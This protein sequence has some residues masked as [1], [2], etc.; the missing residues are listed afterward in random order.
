MIQKKN[1]DVSDTGSGLGTRIIL[2]IRRRKT[3]YQI[4]NNEKKNLIKKDDCD[5]DGR[6]RRAQIRRRRRIRPD[7]GEE[8][9]KG[10]HSG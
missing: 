8:D 7:S 6:G 4:Q 2:R 5:G 1:D 3:T 9:D 10:N